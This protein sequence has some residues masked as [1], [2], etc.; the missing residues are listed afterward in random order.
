MKNKKI[1]FVANSDWYLFNFR[2]S[3]ANYLRNNGF[4]VVFVAP[5]GPY[6]SEIKENGYQFIEWNVGRR[7]IAPI[8]ELISLFQLYKIYKQEK[9]DLIHHFTVKPV[10]YGS[11]VGRLLKFPVIINSITGLGYIFLE[12]GWKGKFLRSILI[13]LYRFAFL[14]KKLHLIF[15]NQSDQF[16]FI[17]KKLI[18]ELQSEVIQGVG[19]D[20]DYYRPTE[21]QK[22]EK[23]VIL[24]PARM[25]Y[26]KGLGV[27]ADA[28]K[29]LKR[30]FNLRII[31]VGEIDTGNPST[32][33][34]A[35]I[36]NWENEGLVEWWGFQKDMLPIY[37]QSDVVT[38][39]SF[40]EG[41]PTVLIEAASC[42][43]PI[44]TTDVA[45]CRDVVENMV[46]GIIVPPNQAAPLADAIAYLI[47]SHEECTR[48]GKAGRKIV[49][50][51]FTS[52]RVNEATLS[53][54]KKFLK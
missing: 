7:T 22:N 26:D 50:E 17:G 37:H 28:A 6:V 13:P 4:E 42:E 20:S 44:V 21:K 1:L 3:L 43:C 33:D 41:L 5:K 49:L 24:F 39:P 48:M 45:G 30:S 51:K 12:T 23:P 16:L 36:K 27:L 47:T 10:L 18:T 9:A 38:L 52:A 15:E 34:E 19:V 8:N 25:L 31:L 54:Y 35:T 29:I 40:G 46:N 2:F 14:N 53:V 11:I 32:V